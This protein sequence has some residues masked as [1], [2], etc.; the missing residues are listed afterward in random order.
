MGDKPSL[1]GG[2]KRDAAIEGLNESNRMRLE[3]DF[4]IETIL[5]KNFKK[6]FDFLH[7]KETLF[8]DLN[9]LNVLNFENCKN[10][11]FIYL[12]FEVCEMEKKKKNGPINQRLGRQ[13]G[14]IKSK[15]RINVGERKK[16]FMIYALGKRKEKCLKK[17]T[18]NLAENE[19]EGNTN[20]NYIECQTRGIKERMDIFKTFQTWCKKKL[21]NDAPFIFRIKNHTDPDILFLLD[22][23]LNEFPNWN[24]PGYNIFLHKPPPDAEKR[25]N[26]IGGILILTKQTLKADITT[27]YHSEQSDLVTIRVAHQKEQI[28]ITA[29][30]NR[31]S[32]SKINKIR[33][34]FFFNNMETIF[35][36]LR[37]NF[38]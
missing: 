23:R 6:N 18:Q 9:F 31:P 12:N 8:L 7:V 16:N 17:H 28:F 4:L 37:N 3:I 22:T 38:P 34:T 30:Y 21:T 26:P 27:M 29:G 36:C 15:M 2:L 19:Y 35:D 13:T 10:V 20:G 32:T 11:N 24:I 14:K 1:G 33:N 5:K 25:S